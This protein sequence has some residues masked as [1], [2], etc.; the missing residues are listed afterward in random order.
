MKRTLASAAWFLTIYTVA[1]I[2]WG[3]FVRATGAGAGCGSHWPLCNGEVLPRSPGLDT[4]IEFTHRVTSGLLGLLVAGFTVW[5]FRARPKGHAVRKGAVAILGFV[6]LE[7]LVGAGLVKFEW[8]AADASVERV[9]VMAFHLVNTMLLVAALVMTAWFAEGEHRPR[10]R[11]GRGVTV[12]LVAAALGL[13]LTGS[14]G[15]VTALGDT[16]V[17]FQGV[18][19]EDSAVVARLVASRFYHPTTAAVVLALLWWAV[20]RASVAGSAL[21]GRYGRLLLAVF[22]AQ[23]ASGV[24]NVWLK[25]PVWMQLVH[26]TLSNIVWILFVLMAAHTW[27][28]RTLVT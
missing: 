9:V 14:S 20:S 28:E 15:A 1:V 2:V 16:L 27:G 24:V 18:S 4:I 17:L 12:A 22:F 23:L 10:P 13:V 19:P 7:S 11:A 21:A 3:A 25:A 5:S 6:V 8:V 26:L